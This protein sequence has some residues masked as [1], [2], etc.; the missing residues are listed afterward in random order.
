MNDCKLCSG[1]FDFRNV[2]ITNIEQ[3]GVTGIT[4]SSDCNASKK[5][6]FRFC[7]LCG[8]RLTT[9][10]FGVIEPLADRV[11]IL[12]LRK[13]LNALFSSYTN[14]CD[15]LIDSLGEDNVDVEYLVRGHIKTPYAIIDF[16]YEDDTHAN[17]YE[18][19]L[20][21]TATDDDIDNAYKIMTGVASDE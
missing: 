3:L 15:M 13:S 16:E 7:P 6:R 21:D 17:D 2:Q 9:K 10:N 12:I 20:D 14:W 11:K 5:E 19:V 4:L 18:I 8:R 1:S